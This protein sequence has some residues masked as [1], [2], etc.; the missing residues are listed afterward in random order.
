MYPPV[1][2]PDDISAIIVFS[3]DQEL[4]P[5]RYTFGYG[6]WV[7]YNDAIRAY[8]DGLRGEELVQALEIMLPEE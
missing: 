3:W 7:L 8:A 4:L 5:A 1:E 2:L 6:V